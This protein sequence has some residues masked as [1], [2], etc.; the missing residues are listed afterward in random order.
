M[1]NS[2]R[3][4]LWLYKS[5]ANSKGLAPLF[6]RLT[7]NGTK[8]EISSGLQVSAKSWNSNTGAI[9]GSSGEAKEMN[10]RIGLLKGAAQKAYNALLE[11]GLPITAEQVKQKLLNKDLDAKTLLA[12]F[13]FH[14]GMMAKKVGIETAKATLEKYLTLKVKVQQFLSDVM[15]RKDINLNELNHQ[16][17][18]EFETYLKVNQHLSH[19]TATKYVQFTKKIIHLSLASGW[20]TAN[21]F[22]NFRCSLITKERGYLTMDEI[23]LITKQPI[24]SARLNLPRL[25]FIFSCYTGLSYADMKKLCCRHIE[26]KED[27]KRW[28]VLHRK[29]TGIRS[30]I[31]LLPQAIEILDRFEPPFIPDLDL[32]IL[33]MISN[34]KMNVYLK[35][36]GELCGINKPLTFHLARH[37]FATSVTL[38][39]GV[40]ITSISA[41]LGHVSIKTTQHY[42]K[43]VDTKVQD[44]MYRLQQKLCA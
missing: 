6:M 19:N 34:Q 1:E 35:E 12:A 27:G 4:L 15:R 40:D 29:K 13:D 14:N 33:P 28:V 20:I 18:L 26:T 44:D 41:M 8:T 16:F 24:N 22:K 39:H 37:S 36:I 43:V 11:T 7:V 17:I 25:M 42:C 10:K 2:I 9:R 38:T 21:P 23:K 30:A 31:P 32:P 3:V 5:K